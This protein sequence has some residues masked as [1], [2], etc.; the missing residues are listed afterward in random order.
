VRWFIDNASDLNIDPNNI[1]VSGG[2]AGGHL[3]AASALMLHRQAVDLRASVLEVPFLDF[4][5]DAEND[6]GSFAGSMDQLL[7]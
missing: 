2:S 6:M 7:P 1:V 3:A 4:V 5:V